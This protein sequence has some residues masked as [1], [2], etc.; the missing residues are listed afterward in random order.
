M[1]TLKSRESREKEP[2]PETE[3]INVS[4]EMEF[5]EPCPFEESSQDDMVLTTQSIQKLD[6]SVKYTSKK[7]F[8]T[9]LPLPFSTGHGY[10]L[11]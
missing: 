3:D 4:N 7:R 10:K 1:S 5:V 9:N 6:V 8:N 2:E 11:Y